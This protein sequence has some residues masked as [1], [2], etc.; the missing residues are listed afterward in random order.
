MSLFGKDWE[1][2][3]IIQLVGDALKEDGENGNVGVYSQSRKIIL[4]DMEKQRETV[5]LRK[6]FVALLDYLKLEVVS[7][8]EIVIRKKIK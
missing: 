7:Q 5:E 4:Y 1:K 3:E 8:D 2:E 6:L